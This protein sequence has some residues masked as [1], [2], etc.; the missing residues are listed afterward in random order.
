M[1]YS[2]VWSIW[3]TLL[4]FPWFSLGMIQRAK[5]DKVFRGEAVSVAKKEKL[6]LGEMITREQENTIDGAEGWIGWKKLAF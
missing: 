3:W 4:F 2:P 1:S 6:E 5:W